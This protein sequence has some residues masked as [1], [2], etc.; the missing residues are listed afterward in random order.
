MM[1]RITIVSAVLWTASC[2]SPPSRGDQ[3][4]SEVA[5]G[6]A[7]V[8]RGAETMAAG[9]KRGASEMAGGLQQMAQGLQRM[10]QS[11]VT[12]VPF[13][14]LVALVPDVPG[15]TR[16]EPRGENITRPVA[17]ARAEARYTMGESRVRLEIVDTALSSILIAPVSMFLVAGYHERSTDGE[18]VAVTVGGHPA[19]QEWIARSRRGEVLVLV[20]NR[21]LVKAS[22]DDVPNV[23]VVRTVVD[24]VDLRTLAT[25]K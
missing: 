11:A 25:L 2:G 23:E 13:E 5:R 6:A 8:Q 18:R 14:S 19:A 10:A 24:A 16:S 12:P 3:A 4:A 22:G 1:R 21:F 17:Y 7:Q 20:A 15:W 9:A